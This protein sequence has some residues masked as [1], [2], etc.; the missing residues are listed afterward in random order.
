LWFIT[1]GDVPSF[2]RYADADLVK[3]LF[4]NI[5]MN[6]R[7]GPGLGMDSLDAVELVAKFKCDLA[8]ALK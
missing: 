4:E 8:A 7:L 5:P 6:A 1:A 3:I 2:F